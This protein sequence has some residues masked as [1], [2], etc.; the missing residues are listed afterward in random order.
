MQFQLKTNRNITD[1]QLL[2]DL[3][4]A[5]KKLRSKAITMEQ[6]GLLGKYHPATVAKRFGGWNKAIQEAGLRVKKYYNIPVPLLYDNI[7]RLWLRLDRQ[8]YLSDL[9][10]PVSRYT[11]KPYLHRFG[12]WLNALKSFIEYTA[13]GKNNLNTGTG[14]TAPP[15][16]HKTP[17][18]INW[19]LRF[20][21]MKRDHFRCMACGR[22]PANQPDVVLQVDHILPWTKGGE[23]IPQN[24]QTLCSVCNV[25]KGKSYARCGKQT[26]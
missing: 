14:K 11:R 3:R 25:G 8:P 12:T 6:Y 20:L 13:H 26:S 1:G 24:L 10:P 23:T 17:R 19:R 2:I 5:A 21:V 22:S 4:K 9:C 15:Q 7:G 18:D 16:L